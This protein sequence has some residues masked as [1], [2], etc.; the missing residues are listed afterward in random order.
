MFQRTLLATPIRV[1]SVYTAR[2]LILPASRCLHTSPIVSKTPTEKVA[3][4]AD[5]V[6]APT[7]SS[8]Q[9][10]RENHQSP[11]IGQQVGRSWPRV[12]NR[13]WRTSGR[14]DKG[15]IWSVGVSTRTLAAP[16]TGILISFI[17]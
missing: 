3:E 10:R 17:Q 8:D 16:H 4:V 15:D 12:R 7:L 6:C 1:R 2:A 9:G 14:G 13:D 11:T 5:K